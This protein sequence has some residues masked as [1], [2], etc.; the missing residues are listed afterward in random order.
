VRAQTLRNDRKLIQARDALRMCAQ[1]SCKDFIVKDC[2]AWLDQV[3]ASLPTV[4][5]VATDAAGIDI[6]G[7]RVWLDGKILIEKIEGRS[8]E[9]D[10]G[11][12]VFTFEAP[13]GTKTDKQAIVA[14]GEKGKRI[15]ATLGKPPAS[16]TGAAAGVTQ[17]PSTSEGGGSAWKTIGIVT[18]SVGVVGIG[19][20]SFFGLRAMSEKSDSGCAD[21]QC[22]NDAAANTWRSAKD[23]GN[24]STIFFVAGGALAAGGLTLFALAPRARVDVAPSV[25]SGTAAMVLKGTW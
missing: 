4:V 2:A 3:Q 21:N 17:S 12:H 15:V 19:V 6:P 8:V 20:G 5:P 7:V 13:D 10:P 11:T 24:L 9:V 25:G 23:A 22:P 14:E 16:P 18:A 1:P